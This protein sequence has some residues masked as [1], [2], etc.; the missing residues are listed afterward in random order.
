MEIKKLVQFALVTLVSFSCDQKKDQHPL[1]DS[2]TRELIQSINDLNETMSNVKQ[3]VDSLN[4][5]ENEND[6]IMENLSLEDIS[7]DVEIITASSKE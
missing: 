5:T 7:S 2:N 4:H 1:I 6:F 3:S